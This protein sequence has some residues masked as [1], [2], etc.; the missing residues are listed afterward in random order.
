MIRFA[1]QR[2]ER[3]WN[4]S[5]L[6]KRVKEIVTEASEY[7]EE[8]WGWNFTITSIFRTAAEDAALRAS[9]IHVDWRAVDVRT[10]GQRQ[11]VIDDVTKHINNRWAYDPSRPH[12]KVCF[13]E[14]H[15]TGPH[16]H[17]QVHPRTKRK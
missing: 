9:G 2:Q 11:E 10:R 17:Y 14:P 7:A 15:G 16:G 6:S 3:E 13:A 12:M 5:R 4:D 1:S 8:T